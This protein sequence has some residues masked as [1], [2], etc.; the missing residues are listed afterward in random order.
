MKCSPTGEDTQ[1]V[2]IPH[3]TNP[4]TWLKNHFLI[5]SPGPNDHLFAWRHPKGLQP[6]TKVEVTNHI[7]DIVQRHE[8]PNLKGH[9]LH[10]GGTLHYLLQGIPFDVVKTMG[11]WS[12]NS[13]TGLGM[14]GF[15]STT[16]ESAGDAWWTGTGAS[17]WQRGWQRSVKVGVY[18][19]A[20]PTQDCGDHADEA[21]W[22]VE[23][24]HRT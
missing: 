23:T 8:L 21:R 5:N 14:P 15:P 1:C 19:G 2:P 18:Q 13:F 20:L 12:G 6:L 24:E 22:I 10:S 17:C 9:S 11:R 7:C 3:L 16:G 4:V